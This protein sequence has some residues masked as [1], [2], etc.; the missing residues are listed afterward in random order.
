MNN[1]RRLDFFN[2]LALWLLPLRLALPEGLF[3]TAGCC[4]AAVSVAGAGGPAL[5]L[6]TPCRPTG[7]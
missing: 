1:N 3:G 4:E 6:E 5:T 7:S 2:A